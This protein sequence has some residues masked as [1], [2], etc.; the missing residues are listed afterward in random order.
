VLGLTHQLKQRGLNVGYGKPLGHSQEEQLSQPF[1]ADVQFVAQMLDI[2]ESQLHPTLISLN[3]GAIAKRLSGEDSQDY[4]QQLQGYSTLSSDLVL[5]EGPG[6]MMEGRLFDLSLL[7]M[8]QAVQSAVLLVLRYHSVGFIDELLT[9]QTILGDRLLGVVVNDIPAQKM[10]MVETVMVPFLERQGIQILGLLP[11]SD[12][13]RSVSVGELVNRLGAEVLCCKERM[14]HM[15]ESLT[16]G[17][18]NVNSALKYFRKGHN[19]AV[20]T[21]GDRTDLQLAALETS[22]QCLILT[23]HISPDPTILSRAEDLEV[24]ILSV[25]LDTLTTVEII[26]QA[27]GQ[28]ELHDT[29]KAKC[30]FELMENHLKVD[31]LLQLLGLDI[32]VQV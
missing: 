15:V 25:D 3:E 13:L 16:I 4:R 23:G 2:S 32:P 8:A 12:L 6:N 1:D 24:P 22:T 11:H 28:V 19:K 9:A 29:I 18:M 27:F 30:V 5:L 21:G 7:D 17:A 20:V 14:S 10:E 26:E 31:R